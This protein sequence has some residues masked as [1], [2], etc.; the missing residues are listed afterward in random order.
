MCEKCKLEYMAKFGTKEKAR[1]QQMETM[2]ARRKLETNKL[3]KK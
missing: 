2:N 3:T 1:E